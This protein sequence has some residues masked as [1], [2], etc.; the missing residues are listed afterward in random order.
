MKSIEEKLSEFIRRA[1]DLNCTIE[2]IIIGDINDADYIETRKQYDLED[3]VACDIESVYKFFKVMAE[4]F[5]TAQNEWFTTQESDLLDEVEEAHE[6]T[7]EI[8]ND[9]NYIADRYKQLWVGDLE[10]FIPFDS[11]SDTKVH[12]IVD[13]KLRLVVNEI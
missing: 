11:V 6:K 4:D 5:K 1:G 8:I 3:F 2:L 9:K 13:V 7:L 10:E 12:T